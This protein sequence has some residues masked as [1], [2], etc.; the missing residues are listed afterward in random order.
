M[1]LD[2]ELEAIRREEEARA[3]ERQSKAGIERPVKLS[4]RRDLPK[5]LREAVQRVWDAGCSLDETARPDE[6]MRKLWQQINRGTSCLTKIDFLAFS[7]LSWQQMRK[8]APLLV[9]GETLAAAKRK[10]R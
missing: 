10:C 1:N 4:F 7:E 2:K 9:E 8:L 6:A 5:E 3:L